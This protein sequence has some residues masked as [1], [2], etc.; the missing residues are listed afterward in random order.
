M[1][2][3]A[4]VHAPL[5]ICPTVAGQVPRLGAQ[6]TIDGVESQSWVSFTPFINLSR[7]PAG[8]VNV[9]FTDSGMPI[10]MQVIGRQRD[11]ISVLRALTV[12]EDLM[13]IDRLA[14]VG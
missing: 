5:L 14:P 2:E 12:I 1:E 11:D 6:G 3:A 7:N 13:A 10:G 8:S 4:F 9:G